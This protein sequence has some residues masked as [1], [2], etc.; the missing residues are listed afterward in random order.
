MLFAGFFSNQ[1]NVPYYFYEFQYLSMFKYGLQ[2]AVMVIKIKFILLFENYF[3]NEFSDGLFECAAPTMTATGMQ[4]NY[5]DPVAEQNYDQNITE[6]LVTLFFIGLGI[7]ILAFKNVHIAAAAWE[8][9]VITIAFSRK[10]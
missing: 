5:C 6:T 10:S 9:S 2:A 4:K 3:Q 1:N 8:I 7:R